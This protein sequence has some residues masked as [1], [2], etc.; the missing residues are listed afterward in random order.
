VPGV[1]RAA[2]METVHR[3]VALGPEHVSCY[4][5]T[6]EPGT[7]LHRSVLQ[8][9][10]HPEDADE[11]LAQHWLAVETLES[12]GYRQ[13]E[14]SNFAR[15]GAECRHNLAYWRNQWYLAVGVGAHGHLPSDAATLL[16][17][18]AAPRGESVRYWHSR[19]I[20]EYLRS[21]RDHALPI[22]GW[23]SIDS[24][25]AETERLMLGLRLEEGVAISGAVLGPAAAAL[26]RQGLLERKGNSVCGTRRGQEVLDRVITELCADVSAGNSGATGAATPQT[27]GSQAG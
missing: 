6:V 14:I 24:L 4:E 16:G 19:A 18:D 10:V 9:R 23:E 7:P 17:L 22:Q 5:L 25:T 26:V 27:A 12:A 2:W 11:A 8:G 13:Y 21:G 3:V 1:T 15:P 20:S